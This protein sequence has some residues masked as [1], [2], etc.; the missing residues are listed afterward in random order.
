MGATCGA[1]MAYTSGAS[2]S[3]TVYNGIHFAQSLVLGVMLCRLLFVLLSFCASDYP[4]D[5]FNLF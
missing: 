4:F 2:N 5:I 1:G 3:T